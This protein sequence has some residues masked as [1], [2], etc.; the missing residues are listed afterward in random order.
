MDKN[1]NVK[2]CDFGFTRDYEGKASY[3]QTF[4][5]TVCYSAPEMLKGEKY[6]GEKV[7]VWSLGIILYALIAGELPF[8]EDDDQDT[9]KK[10]LTEDPKFNDR[11]PEDAKSLITLL[12]SKRPL[13]RPS[14]A[15]I[16]AHPFLTE[17]APAQQAILKLSRPSP[18]STP[19]E[20]T[21]LERMKS[22]GVNIDHVIESVL[23]QKCDV[24]AGWW[25]LLIEKEE[26]KEKRR[27][28]KRR[29][30]EAEAKNLRRLSAASS[31][32]EHIS[33]ALM[34]VDEEGQSAGLQEVRSRGR[35]DRRSLPTREYISTKHWFDS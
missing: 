5:G 27:E 31:R 34:E 30:K 21:T 4:C 28:R 13:I 8:D 6:A 32:L 2:L 1:E 16:L 26:R 3:L 19:L 12:L 23:A 25:A 14:L 17:H 20:K 22:A 7:D 15:D 11:F 10:I 29:E 24:L 35:G 33:A 18:F 9:K